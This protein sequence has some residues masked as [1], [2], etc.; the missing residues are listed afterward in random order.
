MGAFLRTRIRKAP[1][2]SVERPLATAVLA[3]QLIELANGLSMLK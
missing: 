3:L 1:I 2:V